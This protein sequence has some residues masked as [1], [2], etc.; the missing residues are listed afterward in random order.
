MT[1]STGR[2]IWGNQQVDGPIGVMDG[3][4]IGWQKFIGPT[5]RGA[6]HKH[7]LFD[8]NVSGGTG[9]SEEV[10]RNEFAQNYTANPPPVGSLT[11]VTGDLQGSTS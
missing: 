2:M 8:T 4:V 11:P 10:N 5:F 1:V 7:K 9:E 3:C 6:T